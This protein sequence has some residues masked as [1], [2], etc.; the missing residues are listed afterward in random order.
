M[1][2][3]K[4]K[5]ISHQKSTANSKSYLLCQKN[6]RLPAKSM[7]IRNK[8]TTT[9]ALPQPNFQNLPKV[10]FSTPFLIK[11]TPLFIKT[12]PKPYYFLTLFVRIFYFLRFRASAFSQKPAHFRNF[13]VAFSRRSLRFCADAVS[14]YEI[15]FLLKTSATANAAGF[16]FPSKSTTAVLAV[17]G[18][19]SCPIQII[20]PPHR[21]NRPL[22]HSIAVFR[23]FA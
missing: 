8:K 23:I 20:T 9:S 14:G 19:L 17:H 4:T 13:F 7:P 1:P 11:T 22:Q 2:A 3:I 18:K 5:N 15:H 16:K 12:I 6:I 10:A 21:G